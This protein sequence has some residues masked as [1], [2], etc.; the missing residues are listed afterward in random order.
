[1]RRAIILLQLCAACLLGG[2]APT[3]DTSGDV[4]AIRQTLRPMED[5]RLQELQAE[6]KQKGVHIQGFYHMTKLMPHWVEVYQ[7]QLRLLAGYHRDLNITAGEKKPRGL[8]GLVEKLSIFEVTIK[9][10]TPVRADLTTEG[11]LRD[12][13]LGFEDR[14]QYKSFPSI[15]RAMYM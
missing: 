7:E 6:L 15:D 11:A 12:L 1:M 5:Q 2:A 10:K 13:G 3:A 8:M 4:A 9:G 14:V